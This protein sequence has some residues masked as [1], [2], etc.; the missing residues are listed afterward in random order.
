MASWEF[1]AQNPVS[2]RLRV[3]DG[4]VAVSARP[5]AVATVTLDGSAADSTRVE[6]EHG[7]LSVIAPD[8][9]SLSA[10]VE[11]PGG[12]SCTMHT[13]SADIRCQGQL[14]S[15]DIHTASGDVSAERVSG[16]AE[17]VTASGDV[18]LREGADINVKTASG[19]IAVG[20]VSGALT[21]H[22]AS[23]DVAVQQ[24]SGSRTEVTATSGDISV[25]VATGAGVY[26]D[27]WTM[28]G[29]V[30]SELDPAEETSA[31]EMT[32]HCR[33]ISGDVQVSR[34]AAPAPR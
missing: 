21:V 29:T 20:H 11:L 9:A 10:T 22:T 27:L 1:P 23:G 7:M 31:A 24:A 2:L 17:V 13:A 5:T 26:L 34:A 16:A 28:S 18:Y 3:A 8:R 25:A 12:S 33:S 19:D 15:L 30:S 32:V 6:Y 4:I 14:G